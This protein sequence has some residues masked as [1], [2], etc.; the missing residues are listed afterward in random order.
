M[1]R[2]NF[3]ACSS[4]CAAWMA[5]IAQFSPAAFRSVMQ[6]SEETREIVATEKWGRVE[7]IEEG[8]W[9]LVSTAFESKDYTTVCNGG[10]IAGDKGVLAVESFMQPKGAKW[11]AEMAEQLTG[12]WPT[13]VVATHF[14][15]DHTAG[16]SGY[17]TEK[18]KPNV[19]LTDSTKEAAEKSFVERGMKEND[20]E[21]VMSI[22]AVDGTEIDLG[23]RKVSI[24]P[25]SGHTASDVTIELTD[26]SVIWCGDLFFNRVFPNFSHATPGQLNSYASSI[27]AQKD[28]VFIPGH[29]PLADSEAAQKYHDFLGWVENWARE[30][31]A[32][33]STAAK[34]AKDFKLP[35]E[36]ED[37]F[38]WSPENAKLAWLA[39]EREIKV[40]A[41]AEK[42]KNE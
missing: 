21:N 2:R 13:D 41:D 16:H 38:V 6:Q 36:F 11:W 26:P 33:K 25:R 19:W 9:A 10:I 23:N 28:T 17:F 39:W 40:A 20:F 32:A 4:S 35:E 3:L 15:G 12:R 37:W 31:I 8:V 1:N 30:S 7:K 14:H 22:D 29:G 42:N 5:G 24:K 27:A 18:N 34:A